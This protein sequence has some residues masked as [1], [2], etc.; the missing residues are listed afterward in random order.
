MQLTGDIDQYLHCGNNNMEE[1]QQIFRL[2]DAWIALKCKQWPAHS[3]KLDVHTVVAP[4]IMY[5]FFNVTVRSFNTRMT[6]DKYTKCIESYNNHS[7]KNTFQRYPSRE[8]A[9]ERF[10]IIT[11]IM[12]TE[13][14]SLFSPFDF[15]TCNLF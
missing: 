1:I 7:L 5:I 8:D 13:R 11:P 12:T 9:I 4:S 14:T 10:M 3:G 15:R 6:L 2:T